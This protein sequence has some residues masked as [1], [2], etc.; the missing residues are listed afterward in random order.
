MWLI[1]FFS[2]QILFVHQGGPIFM[3][4]CKQFRS[5]RWLFSLTVCE[6]LTVRSS[7]NQHRAKPL[8][9]QIQSFRTLWQLLKIDM[10][11][12]PPIN[13]G[14]KGIPGCSATRPSAKRGSATGCAATKT[15]SYTRRSATKTFSCKDLQLQRHSATQDLQLQRLSAKKNKKTFLNQISYASP[16]QEWYSP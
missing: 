5:C 6:I 7:P 12:S 13:S 4:K 3:Q 8:R 16:N 2:S 14:V 15:F 10:L 1:N 11:S 9:S